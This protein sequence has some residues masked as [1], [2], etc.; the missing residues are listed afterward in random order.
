M[1]SMWDVAQ[2]LLYLVA[3]CI[4]AFSTWKNILSEGWQGNV[5]ND[6]QPGTRDTRLIER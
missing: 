3:I 4:E 2:V 6:G 1:A 5:P